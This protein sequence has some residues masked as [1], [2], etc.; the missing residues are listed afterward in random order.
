MRLLCRKRASKKKSGTV[1]R[2]RLKSTQRDFIVMATTLQK[3]ELGNDE[4]LQMM[5]VSEYNSVWVL[6]AGYCSGVFWGCVVVAW[7]WDWCRGIDGGQIERANGCVPMVLVEESLPHCHLLLCHRS[8][9]AEQSV[10]E[11]SKAKHMRRMKRTCISSKV[12]PLRSCVR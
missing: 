4:L 12:S 1:K 10:D 6:L 2:Q 11:C 3:F 8:D 9:E 7:W 5:S